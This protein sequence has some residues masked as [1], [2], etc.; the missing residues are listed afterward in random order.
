MKV[1]IIKE[2]TIADFIHD[3]SRARSSFEKWIS[4]AKNSDWNNANDIRSTFP[5]AD[6]LGKGSERVIFNI[7]GNNYRMICAYKFKPNKVS[8]YVCWIGTHAEY[9]K[10]CQDGKQYDVWDY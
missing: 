5:A 8:L 10:L 1:T 6:L 2:A 7:G 9:D 4:T 3:N